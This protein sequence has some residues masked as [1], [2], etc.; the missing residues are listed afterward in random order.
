MRVDYIA[1]AIPVFFIL[2]GVEYWI[3][4]RTGKR[5][6]RLNDTIS[7]LT[8]GIYSRL[9]PLIYFGLFV[10]VYDW[11]YR[12]YRL[13]EWSMDSVVAWVLCFLGVDFFY[14]WFHRHTHSISILWGCHEPHHSSEEYNLS[15]ALRQGAF[16]GVFSWPYYLPLA[17][18]G[19]PW[20]M[21][22]AMSSFNTLYQFWIHTRLIGRMGVFEI[23]FNTPSHH[24]VHHG[25]NPEYIDKN[26]GGTLI[27]WDKLFGSF[28]KEEQE[29]VYGTVKPLASW[30]P[31]YTQIQYWAYLWRVS[32]ATRIW[33]DKF[34][35]WF[36]PPG[37]KPRDLPQSG[38][39]PQVDAATH[40]KY[41]ATQPVSLQI[42]IA[43][44]FVMALVATVL[45]L[46]NASM[47]AAWKGFYAAFIVITL[48]CTGVLFEKH[49]WAAPLEL[50]RLAFQAIFFY[51]AFVDKVPASAL[52]VGVTLATAALAYYFWKE[53]GHLRPQVALA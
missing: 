38:P 52:A 11:V 17:L 51:L 7:D 4:R 50:L 45:L 26:H 20:P 8:A 32:R 5:L 27:I 40:R 28:Q 22:A 16:Q 42:Y 29:P 9:T 53:Q 1:L 47:P 48:F 31:F 49:S 41:D 23:L 3:S 25:I 33:T 43:I 46:F 13:T 6:Y 19:F 36:K 12:N 34:L 44:Q 2:M 35:V 21:M 10:F 24:R 30:N 18:F 15:V 39:I 14:Y 37:W